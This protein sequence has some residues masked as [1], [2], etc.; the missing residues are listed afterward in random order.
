ML[1]IGKLQVRMNPG[2]S[3]STKLQASKITDL[4]KERPNEITLDTTLQEKA[5][6]NNS[7]GEEERVTKTIQRVG[8]MESQTTEEPKAPPLQS[9]LNLSPIIRSWITKIERFI[10]L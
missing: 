10:S 2:Q 4:P 1:E 8:A 6:M 3:S 9:P 5:W 7:T